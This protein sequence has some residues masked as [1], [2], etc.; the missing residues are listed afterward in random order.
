MG[1]AENK[2]FDNSAVIVGQKRGNTDNGGPASKRANVANVTDPEV[3]VKI[4]IPSGAVGALIGKGGESM[5]ALKNDSGCRVQMSKNQ[6]LFQ[7]TNERICMVK[8]KV[9]NSMMV[10]KAIIEKIQEKIEPN[11]PSDQFDLKGID[12]CK[13][14]KIVVPNTSAG[15]VIGKSGASIK[16]I[17]E[18]TGAN[19]QVYPKAGS[20]EAKQSMERVITVGAEKN[21]V[22]LDAI[23]RVLE[24]VAA[25]PLHAQEAQ[26]Q[27]FAQG[28]GFGNFNQRPD[29][30]GQFNNSNFGNSNAWQS[31]TSLSTIPDN[32]Y[33]KGSGNYPPGP[34]K[35]NG[36]PILNNNEV[37]SFLDNLQNTLRTSGFTESAVGEIM[38]AMQVLARYNIMGLGL[39]LGV[40]SMAQTR[41]D[42]AGSGP[43]MMQQAPQQIQT[44]S[45]QRYDLTQPL[46]QSGNGMSNLLDTSD[47]R[48]QD[49]LCGN[50]SNGVLIDVLSQKPSQEFASTVI[51]ECKVENGKLEIEVPDLIA[52]AILG[53]KAR[54][55]CELQNKS[56]CKIMVHKREENLATEGFRRISLTGDADCI[57]SARHLINIV[58]NTE[59]AR[60]NN[61]KNGS[62]AGLKCLQTIS[63]WR[64]LEN[65]LKKA[66]KHL[67]TSLIRLKTK[68]DY[69][70]ACSEYER[71]ATCYKNANELDLCLE[72]YLKSADCHKNAGNRFHEAKAKE[73]AAMVSKEKGDL[74]RATEL[75]EESSKIYLQ[76]NSQDSAAMVIDKAGKILENV[77]TKKAI[78]LYTNGLQLV[79]DA[80][81]SKAALSF[82]QRLINLHLKE[83]DYASALRVSEELIDKLKENEDYLKIGSI[84][85]GI[86][87]IELVREDSIAARK[88]LRHLLEING[89][90]FDNEMMAAQAL[91]R[92]YEN[93]EDEDF[94]LALKSGTIRAMDNAYLRLIKNLHAPGG[95]VGADGNEEEDLR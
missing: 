83:S 67:K 8:G 77:D 95:K 85:L 73:M 40:A 60:R 80:D 11:A 49:S 16:E 78:E 93:G 44:V 61:N 31:Q 1:D 51:R 47:G 18:S 88:A 39:G 69:D 27:E 34:V 81:R 63:D 35:Y 65:A 87:V 53:P 17:R 4:L 21:E 76:S 89:Q 55:L 25:D 12:R 14:M 43:L 52:G 58:V 90:T 64:R 79:Y 46:M 13:E 92:S 19:I 41:N 37:L 30:N 9:T 91:I 2:E 54:T 50:S 59:Q 72:M 66:E 23:Q 82:M 57:A 22:I 33:N 62:L 45:T 75:F 56:K 3:Q 29:N 24:K 26:K 28:S 36:I 42:S 70:L 84:G 15:M 74:N 38:Q 68:P 86:V 20:E 6:E 48:H 32:N 5:R 71:A 7:N 94:Q 10:M